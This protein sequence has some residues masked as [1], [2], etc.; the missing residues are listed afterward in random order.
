MVPI[1][2]KSLP[3]DFERIETNLK[4]LIDLDLSD[5]ETFKDPLALAFYYHFIEKN[6]IQNINKASLV[7]WARTYC[8]EKLVQGRL[9][10]KKDTEITAAIL[11][12]PTLKADTGYPEDKKREIEKS[13]KEL[14]KKE[15]DKDGLFFGRPNFTAIILYAK[16]QSKIPINDEKKTL[17]AL[18]ERY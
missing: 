6:N 1:K 2:A 11:T 12:F 16:N 7:S 5:D 15:R 14:L 17:Q 13:I 4:Y 8:Y 3:K 9:S 18:I 10:K